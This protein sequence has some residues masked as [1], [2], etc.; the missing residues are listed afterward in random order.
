MTSFSDLG[1][2]ALLIKALGEENYHTPTPIQS[3]AIPGVLSGKDLLGIAQTGTGKTAAFA[4]PIL[5][6]LAANR[7]PAPR[8]GCRA[9]ILSPTRELATQIGDSFRTYGRHLGMTVSVV[10]GGVAHRPQITAMARGIDVLVATPGRLIDHMD[11]RNITLE[12]TEVFVLDEADQMLDLGFVRPIRRIVSKLSMKRQNLFFSATMPHEIGALAAELLH[13]PVRVSVA[14]AATTVER[15]SQRIILIEQ[16]KKRSLLVELLAD[17][18]MQRTLVFTRTKRG[19][20]KVARHL[21]T[22]GI[23]TAAI[24]GN[25]S[26]GQREAALAAFRADKIRVLVATDIAARGIDIDQVTHVVNF[27]L[28]DVPESYV[29]RIG[30]TARAG[31]SGI[32]IA[33]VDA[34]ERTQLRDIE[35][36]TRQQIAAE[37]R[38]NDKSIAADPKQ[39]SRPE[40]RDPRRPSGGGDRSG[41]GGNRG[42]FRGGER[43]AA[44]SRGRSDGGRSHERSGDRRPD[45]RGDARADSREGGA[46][47][48]PWSSWAPTERSAPDR[49]PNDHAASAPRASDRRPAER[50]GERSGERFGRDERPRTQGNGEHRPARSAPSGAPSGGRSTE[51]HRA[52]PRSGAIRGPSGGQSR[53]GGRSDDRRAGDR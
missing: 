19:A 18:A 41:R 5:H 16:S 45:S 14:P 24:H 46:G 42:G 37:D 40:D 48:K 20:D 52:A 2:D 17:P 50:S 51:G 38:R 9:L 3:K 1:L 6:R 35:R 29:H 10:F 27:E 49:R 13:E 44:P 36:L 12:S 11:E 7:R 26:Q 21:E 22:A 4:L 53:S 25:K 39:A 8:K 23:T 34:E 33:L 47:P 32:A 43:Q 15:V 30:R 31:A 28:P